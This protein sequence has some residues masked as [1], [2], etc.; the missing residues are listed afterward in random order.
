[1]GNE[2]DLPRK[3]WWMSY[4]WQLEE[5]VN[6]VKG[7]QAAFWIGDQDSISQMKMVDMAYEKSRLDLRKTG[8]FR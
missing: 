7:R 5:F 2:V 6:W 8:S 1:V 4:Y 3:D